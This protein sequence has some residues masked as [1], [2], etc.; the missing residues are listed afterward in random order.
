MTDADDVY[1][2]YVTSRM[3]HL[4]RAAYLLCG[5][6]ASGDDLLQRTLTQVYA[7]WAKARRA[8]NLDA[9]VRTV[10]VHRFI[11]ERRRPWSRVRLVESV[12]GQVEARPDD[13]A[14][15]LDLRSALS[16]LPPRQR[17]VLVLRFLCDMS[18]E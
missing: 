10:L 2:E 1:V 15:R 13:A 17:A 7:S 8:D 3:P 11:D 5:D 18:V 16:E 4:R 6:W 9:Y 14:L 12:P